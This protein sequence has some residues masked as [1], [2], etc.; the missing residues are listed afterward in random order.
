MN[1]LP[2]IDVIVLSYAKDE[3]FW[4]LTQNCL[5]SLSKHKD[6]NKYNL[7]VTVVETNDR[8]ATEPF[9]PRQLKQPYSNLNCLFY[10]GIPFNY[11]LFLQQAYD[12][13]LE[14]PVESLASNALLISN[15]DVTYQKNCLTLLL[16]ALERYESVSPWCPDFHDNLYS[17]NPIQEE[18]IDYR[19]TYAVC[20]WSIM[21]RRSLMASVKF[22]EFFPEA[23]SF[24]FQDNYYADV[25]QVHGWRHALIRAAKAQHLSEQ[26]HKL[27]PADLRSQRTGGLQHVYHTLRSKL[28]A[29]HK[30]P[31]VKS[32]QPSKIVMIAEEAKQEIKQEEVQKDR[33]ILLTIAIAS[34]AKRSKQLQTLVE[35]LY[36]QCQNFPV[37]ILALVDNQKTTVGKKRDQ[38]IHLAK[39]KYIAFVD[40]DDRVSDD[41]IASLFDACG[42][43]NN[44]D[45][46]TF[47]SWVAWRGQGKLCNFSL[48]N[49]FQNLP[50]RY[51]RTP[52]H[53]CAVLRSLAIQVS[54][55]DANWGEDRWWELNLLPLLKTEYHIDKILYFYD[56]NEAT[57]ETQKLEETPKEKQEKLIVTKKVSS[58]KCKIAVY[59]IAKNEAMFAERWVQS[60]KDADCILVA[61]TGS[62]DKTVSILKGLG[63]QVHNISIHPWRF[64][65]A[66]NA[67]LA[68]VPSDVNLCIKLDLDEIMDPG[69]REVLEDRWNPDITRFHYRFH[70]TPEW[71]Y[72]ANWIHARE[73][74]YWRHAAHEILYSSREERSLTIE[75]GVSTCHLPDP[76]KPRSQYLP[77]LELDANESPCSRAFFYLGREYYYSRRFEEA[78]DTL[79]KH[80]GY[81][82]VWN[83]ERMASRLMRAECLREL[84]KPDDFEQEALRAHLESPYDREPLYELALWL[85][86]RGDHISGLG[87]A[88][89]ALKIENNP[90]HVH[91]RPSAWNEMI[92]YVAS[93]LAF[94]V[95]LKEKA[96]HYNQLGLKINPRHPQLLENSKWFA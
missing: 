22:S 15:N 17:S 7:R 71:W 86:H 91:T 23:L 93:I 5:N 56:Y 29:A 9:I 12:Q 80:L 33:P 13:I 68:L 95:G 85:Y 54:H 89:K 66:R 48:R 79:Q 34:I 94:N 4:R 83:A 1:F 76:N 27:M 25:L 20:G 18:Y 63:V 75:E 3:S 90:G 11:N 31:E 46:I 40:D 72:W 53:L 88:A 64:D 37:E 58:R 47:D 70:Y 67:A 21:L 42:Q 36:N 57:S 50:D 78:L 44:V 87:Y 30:P 61:D 60:I 2:H 19:T 49:E 38:L 6:D 41:Y 77:L 45:C 84:D 96:Q 32:E 43:N 65:L 52:N 10:P 73:G 69:W 24:W 8:L 59:A 62:E 16:N 51:L 82:S 74:Y 81:A 28:L 39:G 92:Y 26:S 35:N 55:E 14:F